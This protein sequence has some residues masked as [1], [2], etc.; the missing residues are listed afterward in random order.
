MTDTQSYIINVINIV[1]DNSVC[2]IQAPG[3][4]HSSALNNL[5]TPSK[6]PYYHQV[7]LSPLNKEALIKIV[8]DEKVQEYFQ[9]LEITTNNKLSFEG[10]D[11]MEYGTISKDIKLTDN[12]IRDYVDE[13]MCV[14]SEKW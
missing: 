1:P 4:E 12:F 14:V 10:Y 13:H 5:L 9:S 8:K 11:G 2:F 7:I 6:F 3:V